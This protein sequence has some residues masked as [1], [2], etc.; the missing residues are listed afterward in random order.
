MIYSEMNFYNCV[1]IYVNYFWNNI[2]NSYGFWF[3]D[4]FKVIYKLIME[5]GWDLEFKVKVNNYWMLRN[6]KKELKWMYWKLS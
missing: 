4:K 1:L 5:Y 2:G 6:G 3:G